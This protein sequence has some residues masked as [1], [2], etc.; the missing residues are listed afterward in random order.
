MYLLLI[1]AHV[2]SALLLGSFLCL[3]IILRW[4][5]T[6][7]GNELRIGLKTT[8]A[9]TRVGHYALAFLLL[10]GGWMVIGYPPY[11][12]VI[13][14]VTSILLLVLIGAMIGIIHAKL[15]KVI[16]TKQPEKLLLTYRTPLICYS[17]LTFLTIVAAL[18]LMTNRHLFF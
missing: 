9:F 7:T 17:W 3:P 14:V 1:F 2:L 6:L 18:F 10:T 4:L 13:W 5:Y 8:L 15:K 16:L 12:S 11:P